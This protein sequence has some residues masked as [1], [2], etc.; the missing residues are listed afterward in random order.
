MAW[1]KH[2]SIYAGADKAGG[3]VD[4]LIDD[5]AGRGMVQVFESKGPS[6][7]GGDEAA[8]TFEPLTLLLLAKSIEILAMD[9]LDKGAE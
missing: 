3:R 8:M 4:L 7:A 2:R 5:T 9:L 1:K 6:G